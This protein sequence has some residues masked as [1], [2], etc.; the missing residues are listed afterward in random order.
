[1][2]GNLPLKCLD[3]GKTDCKH[4]FNDCSTKEIERFE[5]SFLIP[6]NI[7]L[8]NFFGN[9]KYYYI[10]G[11][12]G[13]GKTCF[14]RYIGLKV[15]EMVDSSSTFILFK[16]QLKNH[17]DEIPP[18][19]SVTFYKQDDIIS[20][21]AND[22][23]SLWHWIIHKQIVKYMDENED[24]NIFKKDHSW[25][26]YSSYIKAIDDSHPNRYIPKIKKGRVE[27]STKFFAL[28]T[29][30]DF[31]F[32]AINPKE[33]VKF[34]K[35]IKNI[36]VLYEQ[37]NFNIGN[38]YILFDEL[39][40]STVSRTTYKKDS[41]L[42]RDL[43][44][45]INEFNNISKVKNF[46]VFLIAAIRSEVLSSVYSLGKEINKL[47]TD[48]GIHISW[49]YRVGK[50]IDHPLLKIL[51]KRIRAAEI[52]YGKKEL[53]PNIWEAYFSEKVH[54]IPAYKYILFQTWYKPRDIV[55]LLLLAQKT[56]PNARTIN[57]DVLNSIKKDYSQKCWTELTEEL[58]VLY[59]RE[60]LEA[61][62]K[63]LYG[64]KKEFSFAEIFDH[65]N[66]L[67]AEFKIVD[68]LL[69]KRKLG[70]IL[71]KLY[72]VGIIGNVTTFDQ[73]PKYRFIYKGDDDVLHNQNMIIHR[74]LWPFLAIYEYE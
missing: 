46:N 31:D 12:K 60:E 52:H 71:S 2:P 33:P 11:Q 45:T 30:F 25:K 9:L 24:F 63:M 47:T 39:E 49:N 19:Y 8:S 7:I 28:Y 14:L 27:L 62:K 54:R 16:S 10:I 72:Q 57:E 48:Y 40:L 42:I 43:I 34:D 67:R 32:E 35:I 50:L 17:E 64:Y 23:V 59:T 6:E 3:F 70:D 26:K 73:R 4:E 44:V 56:H 41:I 69:N 58:S 21:P 36:N 74:G 55:R 20:N 51:E 61:I 22:Y 38:L 53:T 13:A 66:A 65:V 18:N 37:L 29:K 1:M 15:D 5:N 68:S